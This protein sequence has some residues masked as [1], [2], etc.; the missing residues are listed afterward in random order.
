MELALKYGKNYGVISE[1]VQT[2]TRLQVAKHANDLFH[3]AREDPSL[4]HADFILKVFK[5]HKSS[6]AKKLL[7]AS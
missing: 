1:G 7:V 4:P 6:Q 5:P 2:K 3:K